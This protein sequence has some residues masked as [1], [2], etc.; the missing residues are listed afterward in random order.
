MFWLLVVHQRE[1]Y[2][3]TRGERLS[4]IDLGILDQLSRGAS[5]ADCEA[6]CSGAI[7]DDLDEGSKSDA[8]A[9]AAAWWRDS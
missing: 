8:A 7:A 5:A 9:A 2:C 3:A 4:S 1:R 6:W